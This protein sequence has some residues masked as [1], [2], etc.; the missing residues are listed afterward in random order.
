MAVNGSASPP[1]TCADT[2]PYSGEVCSDL[3]SELQTCFS[4]ASLMAPLLN[5]PASVDQDEG[6]SNSVQLFNGLSFLNPSP[7]CSEQVMPFL[8]LHIFGLCDANGNHHTTLRDECISL[9]DDVCSNEWAMAMSFLPAGSLPACE[10]LSDMTDKCTG[11]FKYLWSELCTLFPGN[12]SA[13]NNSS[14]GV[15]F[16]KESTNNS[17]GQPLECSNGF[18]YDQNGTGLCR[19]EC[20]K[21]RKTELG[22]L[23]IEGIAVGASLVASVMMFILA[24]KF[25]RTKM[26]NCVAILTEMSALCITLIIVKS[27]A[28]WFSHQFFWFTFLEQ[29][30]Y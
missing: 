15:P 2:V 10:D 9:R 1:P 4:G 30:F 26:Y 22:R 14:L 21:F 23:A 3:L 8:C 29:F 27:H 18:F 12:F 11:M 13:L 17:N 7:E 24:C 28:G 5:I 25:Q 19:P 20:G 6:E 16:E